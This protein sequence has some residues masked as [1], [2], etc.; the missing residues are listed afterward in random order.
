M[1]NISNPVKNIQFYIIGFLV[2]NTPGIFFVIPVCLT[3][4]QVAQ[5]ARCWAGR[6]GFIPGCRRDEDFSLLLRV[7]TGPEVHS[8]SYKTSTRGFPRGKGGRA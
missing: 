2:I 6:P 5:T 3:V 8:A 1:N 4:G 7:Q